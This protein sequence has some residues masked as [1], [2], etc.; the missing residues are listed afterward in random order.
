MQLSI[1]PQRFRQA[2]GAFT[3]GV[4]IVTAVDAAGKDA[5]ITANSFNSV[6][7]SPPLVLWSLSRTSSCYDAFMSA[8]H[9][10]VHVLASDQDSL[11]S[12]FAQKGIDR[13]AGLTPQRGAGGVALLD[14]CVARFECRTAYQYE[15][16]DHIIIVG[17][18]LNFE[19]ALLEPLVFK[20]GRFALA[21]DKT[22]TAT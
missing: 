6:S 22:P 11:A 13:F 9:F 20:R 5:G 15:G 10:A 3:T 2:L 14:G 21:V 18:V 17:E 7:L 12:Q 16:G 19:H 1:D 8:R 4:T